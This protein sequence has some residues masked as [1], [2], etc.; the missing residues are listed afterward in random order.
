MSGRPSY[1]V[2]MLGQATPS[3]T[4]SWI[5]VDT[6]WEVSARRPNEVPT[7]LDATKCSKIFRVFF[8]DAERSDSED[9]P[10]ARPSR[11]DLV[12]FGEELRYSRKAI[13]E[14]RPDEAMLLSRHCSLEYDFEQI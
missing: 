6:S 14:D 12:L 11:L 5:S 3:S 13:V 2:W 1:T 8:T 4:Q 9:R 10:D 7:C